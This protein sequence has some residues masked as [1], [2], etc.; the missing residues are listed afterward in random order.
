MEKE[1]EEFESDPDWEPN[2]NKCMDTGKIIAADGYHEYLGYDYLP[3]TCQAAQDFVP[4]PP[5]SLLA[6]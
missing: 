4:M 3:C 6:S 5:K 1:I 2:C